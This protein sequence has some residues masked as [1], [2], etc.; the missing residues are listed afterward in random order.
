[1][2]RI[3]ILYA[4]LFSLP[5]TLLTAQTPLAAPKHDYVWLMGYS[6]YSG[7]E[8]YGG[9]RIDFNTIPPTITREDRHMDLEVTNAVVCNP[10]GDLMFYTNGDYISSS[11]NDTMENGLKLNP[12]NSA[13][14]TLLYQGVLALPLPE[15]DH[16]YYLIHEMRT[17]APTPY[18]YDQ[19][20]YCLY[21]IVDMSQNGGLGKVIEKNRVLVKDTLCYGKLTA[22][23]HANG[24]DWWILVPKFDRSSFFRYLL[25]P[26]G[27][28]TFPPQTLGEDLIS[29]AGQAVFSPDGSKYVRLNSPGIIGNY[30]DI[31]DF[32]R[33][34]G[35]L[36]NY[37]RVFRTGLASVGVAISP[38]SRFLYRANSISVM[39]YDLDAPDIDASETVVADYDGFASPLNT[40]FFMAQLAPDGKIYICSSSSAD[41]LH[42]IEEPDLPGDSCRV[43][44]HAINLPTINLGTVPNH[45]NYRLGPLDGT[46]CDTLGLDNVPV[47]HFVYEVDSFVANTF[48]FRDLSY[49]EP[50]TW[51]WDFGDGMG[52][53][54]R[55]PTHTF[56]GPGAWQ[57]CL[58]VS[59]ANGADTQ[60]RT[61]ELT[62]PV[63]EPVSVFPVRV[64]PSPF[65][66]VLNVVLDAAG[67]HDVFFQLYDHMGRPVLQHVLSDGANVL[68]TRLLPRGIYFW[69]VTDGRTG[70]NSGTCIK[71][72]E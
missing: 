22:T 59:N 14:Q 63:Q 24:R 18:S 20:Y 55:H 37:R 28:D 56:P 54:L 30:M 29:N 17:F 5:G 49:Y 4:L 58:S 62:V 36:S 3:C 68:S 7:D 21:T 32:D 41:K 52:S 2:N 57:V 60:C 53:A 50:A 6:S 43:R 13:V 31:Y 71:T 47:A 34:E 72:G 39:Q 11:Q 23:R 12:D 46:A 25:T 19:I 35:L 38:N 1:M 15:N 64:S 26:S 48:K 44:Q 33:C 40:D 16:L 61:I 69:V 27:I 70:L 8:W 9:T 66:D 42:V 67:R 65:S 45:P 10:A 51:A